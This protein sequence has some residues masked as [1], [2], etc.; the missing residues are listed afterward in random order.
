MPRTFTTPRAR[1]ALLAA[2]I[3]PLVVSYFFA[4][5]GATSRSMAAEYA[6]W[7]ARVVISCSAI[8]RFLAQKIAASVHFVPGKEPTIRCA[9]ITV[10]RLTLTLVQSKPRSCNSFFFPSRTNATVSSMPKYQFC[11]PAVACTRFSRNS[12]DDKFECRL[13]VRC[14]PTTSLQ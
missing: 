3:N 4:P 14:A 6:R 7:Q 1:E 2:C 12:A 5:R 8:T 10:L 13:L 11:S 9:L